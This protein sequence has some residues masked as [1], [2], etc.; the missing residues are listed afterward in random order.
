MPTPPDPMIRLIQGMWMRLKA[1]RSEAAQRDGS[2][3]LGGS[4]LEHPSC[5]RC[6]TIEISGINR[7]A[8]WSGNGHTAVVRTTTV[9]GY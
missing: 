3:A 9:G 5:R 1:R 8:I 7:G 6:R 2:D 4:D